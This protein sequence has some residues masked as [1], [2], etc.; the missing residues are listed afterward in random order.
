MS[1]FV[2][3]VTSLPLVLCN[4][5]GKDSSL[6]QH[7]QLLCQYGKWL[8]CFVICYNTNCINMMDLLAKSLFCSKCLVERADPVIE[9]ILHQQNRLYATSSFHYDTHYFG[10]HLHQN[11]ATFHFQCM[12]FLRLTNHSDYYIVNES[13]V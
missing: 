8:F 3:H 9:E 10:L 5:A 1:A 2:R 13:C 11:N 7:V 12:L 6:E 4:L